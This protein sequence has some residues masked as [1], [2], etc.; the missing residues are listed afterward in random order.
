MVPG[1][2]SSEVEHV[3]PAGRLTHSTYTSIH[4][5]AQTENTAVRQT[6]NGT[7]SLILF[8][9]LADQDK[10]QLVEKNPKPI[11]IPPMAVVLDNS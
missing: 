7:N 4:R 9:F 8:S 1:P 11:W 10:S 2:A 6:K 3:F 5:S